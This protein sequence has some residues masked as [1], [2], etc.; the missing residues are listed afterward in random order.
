MKTIDCKK[1]YSGI[2]LLLSIVLTGAATGC[3]SLDD[4][5]TSDPYGGGK[6]ALGI[7]LSAES[8]TPASGYPGDTVVFKAEGLAE[9]YDSEKKEY[10]FKFYMGEVET[11]VQSATDTTLTVVVPENLSTG[12]TYLVLQ[13]QVFYGPTF[14]VLGNLTVDKDYGLY[15]RGASAVIYDYLESKNAADAHNFYFAG[16]FTSVGEVKSRYGIALVDNR[17]N[18]AGNN[19]T[20]FGITQGLIVT[21][22]NYTQDLYIAS[23]SY[24][25]DGQMLVSGS[26]SNYESK[27]KN[28]SLVKNY[29]NTNNIAVLEKNAFPDTVQY[30]FD[31]TLSST[32]KYTPIGVSAFN[33]GTK[34]PIIRSFITKDQKV[35]AVGNL[36]QYCCNVYGRWYE[37]T[38][39]TILPVTSAIRM[40]RTG[41]L[42][43]TYRSTENGYTGA[44]GGS[45]ADAY[46]DE[47]D[48]VVLV[49][50]FTSFDGV[51]AAGIVR[52]DADGNVDK[53]FMSNIGSGPNGD[54]TMVRYNKSLHKAMIVGGFTACNGQARQNV[55]MLNRDGTL[56]EAFA[57]HL[58]EGGAPT[59]ASLIDKG[60]I[61]VSGT[62]TRYDGI[63]RQGFLVLN[64]DGNAVQRFNVPGPFSGQLQQV[65]ET[66]TTVGNYGLLLMGDFYRFNGQFA[67]NILMLEAD[68]D[69]E[70][71][72]R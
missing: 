40:S 45:I 63:P 14:P 32:G 5:I 28:N 71:G 59:F 25:D 7:K 46:M 68:F 12:I 58:F 44:T 69:D 23:I 22:F 49:G 1:I 60:K 61:V 41:E 10:R 30:N 35:I 34:Q 8:P 33:G 70:E 55:A 65:V 57:P 62:F 48:G 9:W 67:N 24:F 43:K 17:G 20:H 50:D 6:E 52:L 56:D 16:G 27:N 4:S 37:Q 2:C 66:E 18:V 38:V 51:K 19:T 42:D 39:E 3:E 72:D 29:I 31:E 64:M 47:E 15:E 54:V 53:V 11:L 21:D 13:N 26:F 36:A